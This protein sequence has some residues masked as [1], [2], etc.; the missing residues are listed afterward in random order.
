M[1][2]QQADVR[3]VC[4]RGM[5]G[6]TSI[7]LPLHFYSILVLKVYFDPHPKIF[8]SP[9]Y[10]PAEICSILSSYARSPNTSVF[11]HLYTV[12]RIQN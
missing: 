6:L 2:V 4:A 3:S 8:F 11:N 9:D 5:E 1:A 10:G 7:S 12:T